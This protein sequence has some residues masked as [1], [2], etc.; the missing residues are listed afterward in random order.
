MECFASRIVSSQNLGLLLVGHGARGEAGRQEFHQFHRLLVE[1]LGDLPVEPCFLELAEPTI[2]TGLERLVERGAR[3]IIVAPLLLFAA[4]HAKDDIPAAVAIALANLNQQRSNID[5]ARV[6]FQTAP[7]ACHEKLLQLSELRYREA[8]PLGLS[9][10]RSSGCLET[11]IANLES[12]QRRMGETT[13]VLV[14]RGSSDPDA[15]AEMRRFAELRGE[16]LPGVSVEVCFHALA[17]PTCPA[18]LER[19]ARSSARRVIVQPHVL[20]SGDVMQ[21]IFESALDCSRIRDSN[22]KT[23]L[24]MWEIC[25]P[26]GPHALLAD[27]LE[28]ILVN[29]WGLGGQ[30]GLPDLERGA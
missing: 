12:Q 19:V 27:A 15:L 6:L 24:Q 18:M 23:P 30:S 13:L 9:E 5:Q 8:R 20:F 1:R 14:G 26:L 11:E 10:K 28:C 22:D 7:L 3:R 25:D 4:R 17:D 16:R 29:A 21:G 2:D